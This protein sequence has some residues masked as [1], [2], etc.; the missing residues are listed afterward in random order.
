MKALKILLGAFLVSIA[1]ISAH[2]QEVRHC[3]T[4]DSVSVCIQKS[5]TAGTFRWVDGSNGVE[6]MMKLGASG[7]SVMVYQ[8]GQHLGNFAPQ[9]ALPS[10]YAGPGVDGNPCGVAHIALTFPDFDNAYVTA[11][12]NLCHL[13]SSYTKTVCINGQCYTHNSY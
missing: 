10:Y 13:T 4:T 7:N 5:Y 1:A 8:N 9:L 12:E 11:T 6:W 3:G 2:A